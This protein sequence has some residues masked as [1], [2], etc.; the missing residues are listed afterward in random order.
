MCEYCE[1]KILRLLDPQGEPDVIECDGKRY[2]PERTCKINRSVSQREGYP[3]LVTYTCSACGR[4]YLSA[5][6]PERGEYC[7]SCGA[8]VVG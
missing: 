5:D 7:K 2:V 1:P 3:S 6:M 4:N 8:K